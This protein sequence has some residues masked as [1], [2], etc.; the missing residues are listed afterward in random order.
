MPVA[1]NKRRLA[2]V[3]ASVALLEM[4]SDSDDGTASD[5]ASLFIINDDI[6]GTIFPSCTASV[7]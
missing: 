2:A 1:W 5:N 7:R 6:F 4:R 3:S